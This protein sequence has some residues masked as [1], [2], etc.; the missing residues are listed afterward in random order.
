MHKV[1]VVEDDRII[2]RGLC[3]AIPWKEHGFILAGEAPDGAVALDLIK[4]EQP[5]VVVS[6]INMPFMSG[7][8]MAKHVKEVSPDTKIIFLTGYEEFK[9]AQEAI[10]LRAFDYLLKPVT[11]DQLLQK[12][13]EAAAEWEEKMSQEK[14]IHE[15]I[16]LLQQNFFQKLAEANEQQMDIEQEL[17]D[18]G[19]QMA[20]PYFSVM[21]VQYNKEA[22]GPNF[23]ALVAEI[24]EAL[25][26]NVDSV[27]LDAGPNEIAALLSLEN[28]QDGAKVQLAQELFDFVS[29]KAMQPVTIS[30]GR[31]YGNL[32]ELRHAYL[33]SRLALD[34]R[35]I[36]GTGR[37]ISFEDTVSGDHQPETDLANLQ[38]KLENQ[39]KLGLPDKVKQTLEQ[40]NQAVL[41]TKTVTLA[42]L[43][44][45][46]LKFSTLLIFEMEKWNEE[47][48]ESFNTSEMYGTIMGMQ[49]L[50]DMIEI[51]N[52][53]VEQWSAAMLKRKDKNNFSH[54][55]Q[56]IEYMKENY[57]D[58]G[59]TL[60][61]LAEV[62]H[63]S[64]PY[65]SNLFK[66]EKGFNFGDYLLELRMK[67]AMELLRE[68]KVRTSDVSEK[69]GYSNPQY[70]SICFKKYTGY[71]PAEYRKNF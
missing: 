41:E 30:Y 61:K 19:I 9:Y 20:G 48:T 4:K 66:L 46:A 39:I 68:G 27:V 59:L 24:T 18:L 37:V 40:L 51:L 58:R 28:D 50:T 70:F 36:M 16:P 22:E 25:F 71:T 26:A 56:A 38:A 2:R 12:A 5:Q 10:K 55:D 52:K 67:K 65:L 43:R 11:G 47:Q 17:A 34:L 32:F 21:L 31:T 44:V 49:T 8:E 60:Q 29:R 63:V 3:Q 54:V 13:K 35:H 62:I 7:L 23:K 15:T 42:D 57:H 6:D 45:I 69:V 53:L 33:E 14:R 64:T 1:I